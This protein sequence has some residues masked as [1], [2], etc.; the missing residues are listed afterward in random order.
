MFKRT[1]TGLVLLGMLFLILYLTS[2]T[3]FVFDGLVM[4]FAILASIEMYKAMKRLNYHPSGISIIFILVTIF[5]LCYF[6][7]YVGLLIS[8]ILSFLTAFIVFIFNSK[9][10]FWDFVI[11]ILVLI[12]PVLLLGLAF[13]M[14][15]LYGILPIMF[16]VSAALMS[17]TIAYYG[18]SFFGKKKIFPKI[19]PK[20]TYAGSLL[21]LLGGALGGLLVYA[22]FEIANY[23]AHIKFTFSQVSDYPYII[24]IFLGIF[25]ALCSE[26][27]DLGASRIKREVGL[28]DYGTLLGSHGGVMDRIDSVLFSL[29]IMSVFMYFV[30]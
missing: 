16:A 11:S 19:S 8:F 29:A 12:Y 24:Y 20:K 5:P 27:G 25:M 22:L 10:N 28:K 9:K 4:L 18:G 17:D 1:I 26:I 7:D 14:N 3:R 13:V 23:P 30:F 15:N 21:G 2:F 6:F